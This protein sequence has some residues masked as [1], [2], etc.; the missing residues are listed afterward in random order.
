MN[1]N[2][3]VAAVRTEASNVAS[4]K[5]LVKESKLSKI[6]GRDVYRDPDTGNLYA[7]DTQHGRFEMVNGK[8]G[9]HMGEV[10]LGFNPTKPADTSG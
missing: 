5:G 4:N 10:D 7:V 9:K 2:D 6:N 1:P 8:N 3:R